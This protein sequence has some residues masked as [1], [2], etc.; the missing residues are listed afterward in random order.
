VGRERRGKGAY[1]GEMVHA[2]EGVATTCAAGSDCGFKTALVQLLSYKDLG[3]GGRIPDATIHIH[4]FRR[5][6][7]RHGLL[8]P[9]LALKRSRP[10]AFLALRDLRVHRDPR[11][12][13]DVVGRGWRVLEGVQNGPRGFGAEVEVGRCVL[14]FCYCCEMRR[15]A[16]EEDA[17]VGRRRG[18][19]W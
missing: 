10:P 17:G 2:K 12:G 6:E 15:G 18:I 16:G 9:Q 14:F 3:G 19:S 5:Y 8:L 4:Y 13:P 7:P 1:V 11:F